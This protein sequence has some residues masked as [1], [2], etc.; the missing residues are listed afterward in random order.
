MRKT[1]TPYPYHVFGHSTSLAPTLLERRLGR[2]VRASQPVAVSGMS[3]L[4]P[5]P[6][7]PGQQ[8]N[9][10]GN[11]GADAGTGT[12]NPNNTG[13]SFDPAS[14]WNQPSPA[15]APGPASQGSEPG[16]GAGGGQQP[17]ANAAFGQQLNQQ[18]Q[19]LTF[20]P[21][22]TPEITEALSN[23]NLESFNTAI[24]TQ[25]R[26][27]TQ[28]ALQMSLSVM[29]RLSDQLLSEVDRRVGAREQNRDNSQALSTEIPLAK[30]PAMAPIVQSIFNQAMTLN[31]GDRVKAIAMTKDMLKSYHSS[32]QRTD[33]G[34]GIPPP[35]PGDVSQTTSPTN[36]LET[37]VGR[38]G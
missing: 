22:M 9:P 14:F 29:Q 33:S 30:D 23:G 4:A 13:T 20:A 31:K 17:D 27:A 3:G 8:P 10:A 16:T 36:W 25:L 24:T 38:P 19:S 34:L 32:M 11:S 2:R 21:I 5:T 15:P 28:N 26:A 37:L 6:D 18:L 1:Q 12:E 35:N 7:L